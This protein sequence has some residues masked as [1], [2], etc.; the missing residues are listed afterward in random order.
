MFIKDTK[1]STFSWKFICKVKNLVSLSLKVQP[2]YHENNYAIYF[3]QYLAINNENLKEFYLYNI[4][5]YCK[6][7]YQDILFFT[8]QSFRKLLKCGFTSIF[9]N[10][11][12]S[13]FFKALGLGSGKNLRLLYFD[14]CP[15]TQAKETFEFGFFSFF[16]K[17]LLLSFENNVN[18]FNDFHIFEN[19]DKKQLELEYFDY[20]S[21]LL[22][23][24]CDSLNDDDIYDNNSIVENDLCLLTENSKIEEEICKEP[25]NCDIKCNLPND[26]ESLINSI[27]SI[28]ANEEFNENILA[29]LIKNLN[30]LRNILNDSRNDYPCN[31]FDK[32]D[33]IKRLLKDNF[34][35]IICEIIM[36]KNWKEFNLRKIQ[37][38]K[39]V[40]FVLYLMMKYLFINFYKSDLFIKIIMEISMTSKYVNIFFLNFL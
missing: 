4:D 20:N 14:N 19:Y 12:L 22:V 17:N 23:N 2:G 24:E 37:F 31:L 5:I 30:E 38:L 28:N 21:M 11:N 33:I 15:I 7:E 39:S 10:E 6:M 1:L 9:I 34:H 8:L 27:K 40:T 35:M 13:N 3:L 36:N 32:T 25:T 29:N 16:H 26:I 18:Y